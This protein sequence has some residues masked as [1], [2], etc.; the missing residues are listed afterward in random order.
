MTDKMTLYHPDFEE[1]EA[2]T[3]YDAAA[4]NIVKP[5]GA[6]QLGW[7]VIDGRREGGP[8]G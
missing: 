3:I 7:L 8:D 5:T 4:T 1:A 6:V 2:W